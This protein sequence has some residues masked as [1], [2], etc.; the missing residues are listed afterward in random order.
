MNEDLVKITPQV[1]NFLQVFHILNISMGE[2]IAMGKL[3]WHSVSHCEE[4]RHKAENTTE[5]S[6]PDGK[7]YPDT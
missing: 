5:K 6:I 1:S 3:K 2:C 7:Y 4:T